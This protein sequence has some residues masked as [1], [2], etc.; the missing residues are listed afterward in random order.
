[1]FPY[2]LL[3][4]VYW[5][6]VL[7]YVALGFFQLGAIMA[8]LQ[9]WFGLSWTLALVSSLYLTWLPVVGTVAGILGAHMVFGWPWLATIGLFAGPL[10]SIV[11]LALLW[12]R[13]DRVAGLKREFMTEPS[14]V[15]GGGEPIETA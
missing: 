6:L 2:Q 14:S 1:M 10:F 8:A 7:S 11:T 4:I 15:Q 9:L 12:A 3:S 5:V 13:I